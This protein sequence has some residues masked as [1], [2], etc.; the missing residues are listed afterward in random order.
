MLRKQAEFPLVL[1]RDFSGELVE[2]GT[3]VCSE[4]EIGQAVWGVVSILGT[5][6]NAQYVVVDAANVI[7]LCLYFSIY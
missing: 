5:G 3:S 7:I 6:C 2:K 1:G 4:L